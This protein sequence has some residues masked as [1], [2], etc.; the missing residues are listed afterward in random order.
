VNIYESNIIRPITIDP[1]NNWG[2]QLQNKRTTGIEYV[3]IEKL[4]KNL[5]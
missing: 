3:N 5:G 4:L 2:T 1:I